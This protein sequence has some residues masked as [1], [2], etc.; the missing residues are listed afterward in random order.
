MHYN[1]ITNNSYLYCVLLLQYYLNDATGKKYNSKNEVIRCAAEYN[2][3]HVTPQAKNADDNGPS[4][5]N[6]VDAV[7]F[8]TNSLKMFSSFARFFLCLNVKKVYLLQISGKTNDFAW[9]PSGWT[10]EEKRRKS[11]SSAGLSYKVCNRHKE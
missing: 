4:S 5:L 2:S 10:V 9:L 6:K 11:G 8:H 7:N 3:L 1:L